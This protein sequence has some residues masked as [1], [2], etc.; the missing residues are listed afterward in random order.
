M[1]SDE[2]VEL[3]CRTSGNSNISGD[4]RYAV[5]YKAPS[6]WRSDYISETWPID[7]A[8]ISLINSSAASAYQTITGVKR[9]DKV[10]VTV[11]IAPCKHLP[12]STT[13]LSWILDPSEHSTLC[14]LPVTTMPHG[15]SQW[16]QPLT[17]NI[18]YNMVIFMEAEFS[19][20]LAV[21][22]LL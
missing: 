17:N 16:W 7:D 5:N 12:G 9:L 4:C 21:F 8:I 19:A 10:Y 2:S 13:K 1:I 18:C 3:H 15:N 6:I 11:L 14:S 22:G 20:T